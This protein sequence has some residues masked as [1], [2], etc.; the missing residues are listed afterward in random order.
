MS[1][2]AD[3]VA[4]WREVGPKKWFGGAEFDRVRR[5]LP[6]R[7]LRRSATFDDWMARADGE[8]AQLS[9]SREW[10]PSHLIYPFP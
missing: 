2:A 9:S 6:Q 10:S 5:T 3:I 4:F 7:A 1:A 8:I